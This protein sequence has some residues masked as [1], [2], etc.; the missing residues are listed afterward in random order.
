V[1]VLRRA[2]PLAAHERALFKLVEDD[3][4]FGLQ[5]EKSPDLHHTFEVF[6]KLREDNA[7]RL[8]QLDPEMALTFLKETYPLVDRYAALPSGGLLPLVAQKEQD[9]Q[10]RLAKRIGDRNPEIAI[11]L[12]RQ[13]LTNGFSRNLLAVLRKGTKDKA[14]TLELYKDIVNKLREAEFEDWQTFEFA[15][16]LVQTYTPP[17]AD[18]ATFRELVHVFLNKMLAAGCGQ[19][20]VEHD[21][22]LGFCGQM[23]AFVPLMERFYP[24]E[25]RTLKRWAPQDGSARA[26]RPG[27]AELNELAETGTIDEVLALT[28][29]YPELDGPIRFRAMFM[30]EAAGEWERAEKIANTLNTDHETRQRLD[31]RV[32]YYRS[33]TE[34]AEQ[35]W[36]AALKN[37]RGLP[38]KAR[39]ELLLGLAHNIALRDRPTALK[40]L[41]ELSGMIETLPPGKEQTELQIGLATVYCL[42]QSDRGFGIMEALL[43][44]LNELIAAG[45]KLD[46]YDSRYLR[47]G[48]WN[49]TAEGAVGNLLT[50]LANNAGYFAWSDFDR[51]VT[52]SSQFERSEIRMM[53]QLK[54]AQGILAGP[55]KHLKNRYR[56]RY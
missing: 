45:A 34:S 48:E 55:P 4:K 28:S 20:P 6:Y 13:S 40:A 24:A 27:Y 8:A 46:G 53:A 56:V 5:V 32:R 37:V 1:R 49:M 38:A 21:E 18:E 23:G 29:K 39:T 14:Q 19:G 41:A 16:S 42:A 52:L 26:L 44:K 9:L 36:T 31:E 47:D 43:P 3:I 50:I 2:V 17:A 11:T 15:Q 54:L 35:E 25:V 7:E 10:L 33:Q 12:A 51:A 30:A 22:R